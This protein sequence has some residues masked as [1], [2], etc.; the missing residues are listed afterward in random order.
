MNLKVSEHLV[1]FYKDGHYV[2]DNYVEH[3]QNSLNP[4]VVPI[5]Q[6]FSDW[7]EKESS[8]SLIDTNQ[9]LTRDF[10][11]YAIENL[12][13]ANIL[14]EENS[15]EH[16]LEKMSRQWN[17]WGTASKYFHFNTRLKKSD[18]FHNK[19]E[20]YKRLKD[21]KKLVKPPSIYKKIEGSKKLKLPPPNLYNDKPFL[22]TLLGRQTIRDLNND[23]PMTL[24][25]FSALI[26]LVWGIQ[27]SKRDI[28]V[29]QV[30][31]KTSPSGG[32][33]HPIEVYPCIINVEGLEPGIYHYSTQDHALELIKNGVFK[34]LYVDMA[35]QQEYVKNAS[36]L[37]FYTACIERTMWKYQSPR[38]YRV[39]MMDLGHL[40]QTFYLTS[41]WLELGAFFTAHLKDELVEEQLGIEFN[42]EI[43]LGLSGVGYSSLE[44]K[45]HGRDLRFIGE[46]ND[47][48]C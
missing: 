22:H 15:S 18:K 2:C 46:L 42:K 44:A 39:I 5:L 24:E 36:V 26:Y 32:S 37:F 34:D 27:S 7:K 6:F 21:K 38:A 23:K 12:I 4:S 1:F 8:Y 3:I 30:I 17:Q 13:K 19:K 9:I 40:S 41:N 29:D 47:E 48:N 45:L 14:I 25:K 28:G 16:L 35:A 33:R 43:V 11:D 20:Q 10:L 31:F